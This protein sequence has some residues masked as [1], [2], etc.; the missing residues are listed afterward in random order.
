MTGASLSKLCE[1]KRVIKKRD[2]MEPPS[3][4][5]WERLA[6][7]VHVLRND[8]M[9]IDADR[10][11]LL[12]ILTEAANI[13]DRLME[14]L[15][16]ELSLPPANSLINNRSRFEAAV[17]A[18]EQLGEGI[19]EVRRSAFFQ[20]RE[21]IGVR[22]NRKRAKW[23]GYV[24]HLRTDFLKAM[25]DANPGIEIKLGGDDNPVT[26]FLQAVIRLITGEQVKLPTINRHL[27]PR[28]H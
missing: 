25:T 15:R 18:F 14:E 11:R 8:A 2:N 26:R 20:T 5:A 17:T 21:L 6:T 13:T 28:K 23:P 22:P 27:H 9:D 16:T 1:Q 19:R 10:R 24:G 7:W 12:Q 4:D 3:P